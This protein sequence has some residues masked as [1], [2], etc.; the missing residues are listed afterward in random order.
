MQFMCMRRTAV[1]LSAW[2]EASVLALSAVIATACSSL[3][4]NCSSRISLTTTLV[5]SASRTVLVPVPLS[6]TQLLC[7]HA[8][9]ALATRIG[10][11]I[12]TG[13]DVAA[14]SAL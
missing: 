7:A 12:Y 8:R 10:L 6:G 3:T 4:F 11:G 14:E 2:G 1:A 5:A 13:V 9:P